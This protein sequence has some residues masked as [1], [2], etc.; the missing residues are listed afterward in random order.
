MDF[1]KNNIESVPEPFFV[2]F[3]DGC[4]FMKLDAVEDTHGVPQIPRVVAWWV[5]IRHGVGWWVGVAW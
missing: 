3:H 4:H 2:E 1:S 5:Q